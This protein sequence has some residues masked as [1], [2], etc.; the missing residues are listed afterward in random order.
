MLPKAAFAHASAGALNQT[1][2]QCKPGAVFRGG[3]HRTHP[4]AST[5]RAKPPPP[6]MQLTTRPPLRAGALTAERAGGR[7]SRRPPLS[8]SPESG[9]CGSGFGIGFG[10]GLS[11]RSLLS[12]SAE[13]ALTC[14]HSSEIR[15]SHDL[16]TS[17]S[18]WEGSRGCGV[19]GWHGGV[20]PAFGGVS[21]HQ[22][23]MWDVI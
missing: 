23:V 10:V 11:C 5:P 22:K 17:V 21:R 14:K 3:I 20:A 1:A 13:P 16:S 4:R 18:S 15:S 12:S 2:T 6:T 9:G 8:C 7:S 19:L